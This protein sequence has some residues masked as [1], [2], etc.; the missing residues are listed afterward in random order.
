RSSARYPHTTV[1][2]PATITLRTSNRST[3]HPISGP[4][5][6]ALK[7]ATAYPRDSRVRLHR[8]VLSTGMKKTGPVLA[9]PPHT[10]NHETNSTPIIVHCRAEASVFIM[11]PAP[12]REIA[13]LEQL[14][15]F[16]Q[17]A[18]VHS[19]SPWDSKADSDSV[20][21]TSSSAS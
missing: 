4:A 2:T 16:L 3:S 7:A 8:K 13:T 6:P 17:P 12:R 18:P 9:P 20:V 5:A 1:A 21:T 15:K 19:V 11:E 14:R 10:K